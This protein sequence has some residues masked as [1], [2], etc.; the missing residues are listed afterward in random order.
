MLCMKILFLIFLILSNAVNAQLIIQEVFPNPIGKENGNEYIVIH[1]K[2]SEE[3]NLSY[4]A[5]ADIQNNT[6]LLKGTLPKNSSL[7]VFPNF[8]LNND[9][10]TI[11]L[12]NKDKIIDN[13]S[14]KNAKENVSL[15]MKKE[16]FDLKSE[17]VINALD[18]IVYESK[19]KKSEAL[20][21]NL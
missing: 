12:I 3:V 10:E 9:K 15:T 1:N 11:F 21:P 16:K 18:S 14:Y 8:Y 17:N 7:K 4:Y 20:A 6:L 5:I 2:L 13:F 19:N